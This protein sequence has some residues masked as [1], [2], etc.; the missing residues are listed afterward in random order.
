MEYGTPPGPLTPS[1]APPEAVGGAEAQ[2]YPRGTHSTAGSGAL[3][4]TKDLLWPST[5]TSIGS[6]SLQRPRSFPNI[7]HDLVDED[8]AGA[9]EHPSSLGGQTL[10]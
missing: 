5:L 9:W 3:P 2:H 4:S 1:Q 10:T 8:R 7:P 6:S